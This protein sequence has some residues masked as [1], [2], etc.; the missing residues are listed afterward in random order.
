M[1]LLGLSG[2][3][4]ARAHVLAPR[5]S[6]GGPLGILGKVQEGSDACC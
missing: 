5:N 6:F 2:Y 4:R 1:A 3:G